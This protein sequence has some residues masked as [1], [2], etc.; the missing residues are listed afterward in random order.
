MQ[1]LKDLGYKQYAQR[2]TPQKGKGKFAITLK[3][4]Y[5]DMLEDFTDTIKQSNVKFKYIDPPGGN[6]AAK[7][8]KEKVTIPTEPQ[9]KVQND[10]PKQQEKEVI[11]TES[12]NEVQEDHQTQAEKGATSTEPHK[13]VQK[14]HPKCTGANQTPIFA[15]TRTITVA[16]VREDDEQLIIL[17]Y[18][19][20]GYGS[21]TS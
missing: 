5:T 18:P 21:R 12:Q 20:H 19:Y 1:F 6:G 7:K 8:E 15:C 9:E 13:G 17:T 10:R 16:R 14:C 11:L 2:V 3:E 4:E